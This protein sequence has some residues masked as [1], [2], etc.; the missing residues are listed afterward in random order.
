MMFLLTCLYDSRANA[1]IVDSNS[2]NDNKSHSLINA[3]NVTKGI[4]HNYS[5]CMLD[6]PSNLNNGIG[7]NAPCSVPSCVNSSL[8]NNV[9]TSCIYTTSNL[10]PYVKPFE[11]KT[12]YASNSSGSGFSGIR[13][14]GVADQSAFSASP[15]LVV[16]QQNTVSGYDINSTVSESANVYA[17]TQ[18]PCHASSHSAYGSLNTH[19]TN[20]PTLKVE[21][22]CF[23]GNPAE[24]YSFIKAFDTLIDRPL[25]DPNRKLFFL[26][27]Y[28]KDIAHSLIKGCQHMPSDRG[29]KEARNLLQSYFGQKHKIIEACMRPILKGPVLSERDQRGIIKFSADLTSCL[30][31]LEGM[32]CL[33]RMDNMDVVSKI[34]NRLPPTWIPNWYHESDQIMHVQHKD[35]C[36]KDLCEFVR[37]KT[38]E[39]TNFLQI[40]TAF[41]SSGL[42]QRPPT[43]IAKTFST[44]AQSGRP[45]PKCPLCADNHFLNQC[46][47]FRALSYKGRVEFV[48]E[49]KL[50]RA[51]LKV[52]HIATKCNRRN[53]ACKKHGCREPHTTLLHPPE[54]DKQKPAAATKAPIQNKEAN[55]AHKDSTQIV[56]SGLINL[57]K[58]GRS[59]LPVVPVKIRV[60][61]CA[62]AVV[63]KALLDTGSTHSFIT[64]SLTKE[65]GIKDSK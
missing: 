32:D 28:T 41:K 17:R 45:S 5:A 16:S 15:K 33:D 6:L 7:N 59:L 65:L 63:T 57:P 36:V 43:R 27:H 22:P 44:Q 60:G 38:R 1:I 29:Y 23:N 11:S 34:A 30:Y 55:G 20:P 40:P 3:P 21:P 39:G 4:S 53:E 54:E 42:Q 9:N 12:F 46:S 25:L 14:A 31:T 50:C 58:H 19:F 26:L 52:G 24:Y 2:N 8:M 13:D 61:G 35:I 51:C 62:E 37:R 56:S 48:N 49:Q 18:G 64:E 10:N 47:D